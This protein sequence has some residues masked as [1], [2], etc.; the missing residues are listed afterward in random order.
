[1]ATNDI[2]RHA[3]ETMPTKTVLKI[4]GSAVDLSGWDVEVHYKI[5]VGTLLPDR[6]FNAVAET[7]M[8]IDCIITDA[9]EGKVNIYPHARQRYGADGVT[10][11]PKLTYSDYITP[12]VYKKLYDADI[13]AGGDGSTVP[14]VNQ[15]WDEDEVGLAGTEYPFYIV[16]KK[17]YATSN[18]VDGYLEEQIHNTGLVIISSRWVK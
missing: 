4:N 12:E 2:V 15:V 11:T 8:I 5:P 17:R 18:T 10:E 14:A 9:K 1:M 16:R 6:I 3:G 7:E 13:L